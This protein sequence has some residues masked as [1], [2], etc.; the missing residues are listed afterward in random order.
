MSSFLV[1]PVLEDITIENF[2]H[3]DTVF[4]QRVGNEIIT[5]MLRWLKDV[6]V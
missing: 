5:R 1:V 6:N 3:L 2:R 4:G